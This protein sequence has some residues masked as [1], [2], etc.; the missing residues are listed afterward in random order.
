MSGTATY[1][2]T[3]FEMEASKLQQQSKSG[4]IPLNKSSKNTPYNEKQTLTRDLV[5]KQFMIVSKTLEKNTRDLNESLEQF[6]SQKNFTGVFD[7]QVPT[8]LILTSSES[9]SSIET[10]FEQLTD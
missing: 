2:E 1:N 4:Y 6:I 3:T 9:A 5:D 7:S 10:Q 8:S